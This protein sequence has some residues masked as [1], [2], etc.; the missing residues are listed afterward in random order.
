[1][2]SFEN[3][4]MAVIIP[5]GRTTLSA[6]LQLPAD[7]KD[8]VRFAWARI[9]CEKTIEIIP[10]ADFRFEEPGVLDDVSALAARWFGEHLRKDANIAA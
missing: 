6:R 3:Q 2:Q 4:L 7:Q 1:M 5:A 10:G 9:G 8:L